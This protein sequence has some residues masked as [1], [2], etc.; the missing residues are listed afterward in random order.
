[1]DVIVQHRV[2]DPEF[3][4]ADIPGVAKNAP[5]G[6][7]PLQFCPSQDRTAAVCLWRADS[8]EL[9]RAY[10]DSVTGD[11]AENTYFEV[12]REHAIG[13]PEATSAGAV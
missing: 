1:M 4:F 5:V 3:F 8:I 11:A 2:K 13:L 12:S 10:L 7:Q 6:V 9:V